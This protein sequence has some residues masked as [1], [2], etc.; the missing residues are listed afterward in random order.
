[1]PP[2]L[3][4]GTRGAGAQLSQG[5]VPPGHPL[6]P[7]LY[8][9]KYDAIACLYVCLSVCLSVSRCTRLVGSGIGYHGAT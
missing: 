6:E 9:I 7:P 4:G 2:V 1:M 5:A 8:S 3:Y